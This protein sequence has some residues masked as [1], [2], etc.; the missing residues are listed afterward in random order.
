MKLVLIALIGLVAYGNALPRN[1]KHVVKHFTKAESKKALDYW[2]P[3]RIKQAVPHTMPELT[4]AEAAKQGINVK[5]AQQFAGAPV[6][7]SIRA[8]VPETNNTVFPYS[9]MGKILTSYND[10]TEGPGFTCSATYAYSNSFGVLLSA[11]H[12]VYNC[13]AQWFFDNF[14]FYQQFENGKYTL[15]QI[16]NVGVEVALCDA[17]N[18]VVYAS[19]YAFAQVDPITDTETVGVDF[20]STYTKW[21]SYG[22]PMNYGKGQVLESY[23]GGKGIVQ[24]G[25]VQMPNNPMDDGSDGGPWLESGNNAIGVNAFRVKGVVGV[26]SPMFNNN[27]QNLL[28]YVLSQ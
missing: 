6:Q 7:G 20:N 13:S 18:N 11:G 14:V 25:K 2:T 5:A 24:A 1:S 16:Q 8:V 19:D 22:Y 23:A 26:W 4:E 28:Q 27:T 3:E 21:T 15:R 17:N 9:L 10:P 12:C